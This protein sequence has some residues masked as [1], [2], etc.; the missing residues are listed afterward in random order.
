MHLQEDLQKT[1]IVCFSASVG[2]AVSPTL[3][4]MYRYKVLPSQSG[5]SVWKV[6]CRLL[7]ETAYYIK[8]SL[9]HIQIVLISR[10]K[11]SKFQGSCRLTQH[12]RHSTT[13][14]LVVVTSIK[15]AGQPAQGNT[16]CIQISNC[17]LLPQMRQASKISPRETAITTI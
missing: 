14:V 16:H 8:K 2:L 10:V 3:T 7:K 6:S 15:K 11:A 17:N 9:C 13:P 1:E 5:Q 4:P 12:R